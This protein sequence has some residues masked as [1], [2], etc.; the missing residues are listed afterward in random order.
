MRALAAPVESGEASPIGEA[1]LRGLLEDVADSPPRGGR[2]A[3]AQ[4]AAREAL[5]RLDRP[6]DD[7]AETV[8]GLFDGRPDDGLVDCE[9]DWPPTGGVMQELDAGDTLGTRRRWYRNLVADGGLDPEP[10]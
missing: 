4:L 8:R 6:P 1:E 5:E 7:E 9:T 2:G 10:R 3:Q